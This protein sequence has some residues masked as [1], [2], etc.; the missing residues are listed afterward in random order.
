MG[1]DRKKVLVIGANSYIGKKFYEYVYSLNEKL[2]DVDMVSATD[3]SWEKVDFSLY[4]SV[5]HLSAIVYR[6]EKENL[7]D[8]YENVNHKLPVRIAHKAKNNHVK[9]FIF[10]SSAAVYGD[11]NGC[12]TK[13]T[14]P[15]PSTLYGK[16]K[17]AAEDDLLKLEN[18]DFKIVIIRSPMVYG[19]GCKGN[20][21]KLS[22]IA[23][24]TPIFPDYH[25]KRS[26]IHVDRLSFHIVELILNEE[27]GCY[28]PQDENYADICE[29]VVCIRKKSGKKTYLTKFFNP[30]INHLKKRFN[31]LDKIF[32]DMYYYD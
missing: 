27:Q 3:G 6:K 21:R 23:K 22:K 10:M 30:L 29:L 2:I 32:G 31:V 9:Q 17:L 11:I 15:E 8:L 12:I 19:E 5:L 20:Y 28:F 1:N 14:I 24:F 7:K 25:N 13:E 26:M 4:D 16:T 18:T